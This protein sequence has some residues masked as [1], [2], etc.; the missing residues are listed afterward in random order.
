MKKV[1]LCMV[2]LIIMLI[3][4]VIIGAHYEQIMDAIGCSLYMLL[5]SAHFI[6]FMVLVDVLYREGTE[7]DC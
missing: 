1:I 2:A 3:T 6:V 5:A 7:E 4:G